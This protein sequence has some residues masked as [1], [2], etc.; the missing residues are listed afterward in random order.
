MVK[1]SNAQLPGLL[2]LIAGFVILFII[3][4]RKNIIGLGLI[5]SGFY[6]FYRGSTYRTKERKIKKKKK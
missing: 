3:P 1:I 2:L 4:Y 5:V 6:W